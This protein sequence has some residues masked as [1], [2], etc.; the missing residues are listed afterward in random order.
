MKKN[1]SKNIL[2]LLKTGNK[3]T[4]QRIYSDNRGTFINFA[5]KYNIDENDAADIYQ[6]AI[7]VLYENAIN[8]KIE[9]LNCSISTYLFA[10][11]KYKF[12]QTHREYAKV[13]FDHNLF[14]QE[15]NIEYDVNPFDEGI[16]NQQRLLR[17]YFPKLGERCKEI[18]VLF[19]Y[20]GFNLDE[21]REHLNYSDKSVLKSQ[22]SRCMKQI[23][24]YVKNKNEKL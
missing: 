24:A 12:F 11:G 23:R 4:L 8:G 20:K 7:I 14:V 22:K 2:E 17:K 1:N 18:L 3:D 21:I 9:E 6:D 13:D 15:K 10:I 5:K 19:Y 16:T